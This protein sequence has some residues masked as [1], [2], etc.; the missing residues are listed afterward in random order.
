M[1]STDCAADKQGRSSDANQ[2]NVSLLGKFLYEL[3]RNGDV[4]KSEF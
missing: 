3:Q 2:A 4:F 1:R